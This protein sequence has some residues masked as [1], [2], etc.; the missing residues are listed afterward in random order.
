MRISL[1]DVAD[2]ASKAG[3]PKITKVAQIKARST[4]AYSPAF[5]FYK[6]LRDGIV[7]VHKRDGD[8]I[9]LD[10]ILFGVTEKRRREGYPALIGAYR[11]WWRDKSLTWF[12]PASGVFEHAGCSVAVNPEL[13][14]VVDGAAHVV[15]LYFRTDPLS[16][17]GVDV[18]AG[19][20]QSTLHSHH[21]DAKFAVFD[22]RNRVLRYGR[23]RDDRLLALTSAELAFI[24]TIWSTLDA[25]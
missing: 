12:S 9:E 1:T 23:M 24:S 7:A 18:I 6:Q 11:D 14:L 19:L 22:V 2:V 15:K 16:Q 21:P 20:M 13:G 25:A 8:A 4:T 10:Q 5:D 17:V 3:S